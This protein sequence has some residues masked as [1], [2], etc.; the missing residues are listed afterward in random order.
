MVA[1]KHRVF[2]RAA[3][4]QALP[5][6]LIVS[7]DLSDIAFTWYGR[8]PGA[9]RVPGSRRAAWLWPR[10]CRVVSSLRTGWS[11]PSAATWIAS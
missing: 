9:S 4:G 8:H 3:D 2:P 1:T 6:P 5:D 10:R 7:I 11:D